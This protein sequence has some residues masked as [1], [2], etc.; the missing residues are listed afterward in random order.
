MKRV[1]VTIMGMTFTF[2][3][4]DE[5]RIKKVAE[6][7]DKKAR[8]ASNKRGIVNTLNAFVVALMEIADEYMKMRERE[9]LYEKVAIGILD[10]LRSFEGSLRCA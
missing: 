7:V 3:G 1:Q 9:E 6:F 5:E 4:Q 2:L 8:E 10:K